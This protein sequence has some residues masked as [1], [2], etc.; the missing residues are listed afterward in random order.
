ME[1]DPQLSWKVIGEERAGEVM[2]VPG[3]WVSQLQDQS[4]AYQMKLVTHLYS[5]GEGRIEE[6]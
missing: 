2:Y 1:H 5:E 4:T 3:V 6:R